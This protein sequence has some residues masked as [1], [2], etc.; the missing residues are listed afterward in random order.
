MALHECKECKNKISNQA[1]VCPICGAPVKTGSKRPILRLLVVIIALFAIFQFINYGSGKQKTELNS[2][3]E[4]VQSSSQSDNSTHERQAL[5]NHSEP[6]EVKKDANWFSGF[7]KDEM[8]DVKIPYVASTS[9]N[10]A[11]FDFPYKVEGGSKA[12]IVIRKDADKKVAFISVQKGHMICAYDDCSIVIKDKTG[13]VKKW[14]A[15]KP[16]AG[17]T[18]TLFINNAQSFEKLIESN[19]NIRIGVEFYKYGVKSFDF[20]VTG[21]PGI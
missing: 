19:E 8:T 12:T 16:Q 15:S 14:G 3:D 1:S 17:V 6:V 11:E 2:S 20:D 18:N 9:T 21:Y 7:V 5:D 10:G 4:N 13:K